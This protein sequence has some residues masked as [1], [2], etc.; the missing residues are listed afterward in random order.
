MRKTPAVEPF[1]PRL[2][3]PAPM[4]DDLDKLLAMPQAKRSEREEDGLKRRR[5]VRVNICGMCT[6]PICQR[7]RIAASVGERCR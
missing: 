7:I 4:T 5:G 3:G 1:E 2:E 6:S